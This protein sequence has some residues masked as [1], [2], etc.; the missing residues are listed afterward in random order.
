MRKINQIRIRADAKPDKYQV[1]RVGAISVI[2][3]F[4]IK[5]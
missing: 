1:N 5:F 3:I 4:S 2:I